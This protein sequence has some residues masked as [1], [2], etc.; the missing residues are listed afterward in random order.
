MLSN[1]FLER[2]IRG[3]V[4]CESAVDAPCPGKC[5]ATAIT[6]ASCNPSI[7]A[8][9][10]LATRIGLSPNARTPIMGLS[11]SVFTSTTGAND[12]CTPILRLRSPI[13]L[14]SAYTNSSLGSAPN[15]MAYG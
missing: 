7:K 5:L 2:F 3:S 4:L 10:F 11:A 12:T 15:V 13:R 9:V 8:C 1:A 6:P 14:A